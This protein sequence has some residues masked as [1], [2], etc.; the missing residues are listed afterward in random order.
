VFSIE[1]KAGEM[2]ETLDSELFPFSVSAALHRSVNIVP[3]Q[4]Y[5]GGKWITDSEF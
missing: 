5:I 2:R 4:F 1:L 3:L